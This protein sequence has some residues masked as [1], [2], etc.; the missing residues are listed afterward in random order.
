MTF[1]RSDYIC[2]LGKLSYRREHA[3]REQ[4]LPPHISKSDCRDFAQTLWSCKLAGKLPK[5]SLTIVALRFSPARPPVGK[6]CTPGWQRHRSIL[7]LS[8]ISAKC[9]AC[10]SYALSYHAA[11]CQLC[12]PHVCAS[13]R[14]GPR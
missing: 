1:D 13:S 3:P 4:D 7:G 6:S 8:Q 12:H 11:P 9:Q 10:A 14:L 5:A 2:I